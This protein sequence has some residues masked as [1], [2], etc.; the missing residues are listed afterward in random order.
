MYWGQPASLL[1]SLA[2]ARNNIFPILG[3]PP[4]PIVGEECYE[5]RA[6]VWPARF[7][8]ASETNLQSGAGK[9]LLPDQPCCWACVIKRTW[10]RVRTRASGVLLSGSLHPRMVTLRPVDLLHAPRTHSARRSTWLQL[11]TSHKDMAPA[12]AAQRVASTSPL[13]QKRREPLLSSEPGK[14][15]A[16]GAGAQARDG[17]ARVHAAQAGGGRAG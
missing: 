17:R 15:L 4:Y 14:K 9:T 1:T 13:R 12:A 7:A 8:R 6:A 10:C 16:A 3:R 5:P 2:R 11:D